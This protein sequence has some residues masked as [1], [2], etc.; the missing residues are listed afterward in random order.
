MREPTRPQRPCD[1]VSHALVRHGADPRGSSPS[2]RR[3]RRPVPRDPVAGRAPRSA[4]KTRE[5]A[6]ATASGRRRRVR[7]SLPVRAREAGVIAAERRTRNVIHRVGRVAF[8]DIAAS[9]ARL[10]A[11]ARE[12]FGSARFH[13]RDSLSA[14]RRL[15]FQ[16]LRD[17][18]RCGGP[19]AR[20]RTLHP[21]A[22]GNLGPPWAALPLVRH[23]GRASLWRGAA[24]R[25]LFGFGR[26]CQA[27]KQRRA[28][29]R[30]PRPI[31]G[32]ARD[33]MPANPAPPQGSPAA[34]A[35][36]PPPWRSPAAATERAHDAAQCAQG[37]VALSRRASPRRFHPPLASAASAPGDPDC[38]QGRGV[39]ECARR[40]RARSRLHPV[41]R[42]P[43][44]G[45]A[46][47]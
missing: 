46:S 33:K 6:G 10:P 12:L 15:F 1:S 41:L 24:R 4:K 34:A 20:H 8:A 26:G 16:R 29:H 14:R 44:G 11:V 35:E 3:S 13:R 25:S 31:M 7:A 32:A 9:A 47:F 19:L 42:C 22:N 18:Q 30:A 28:S 23:P 17:A 39:R 43:A 37:R 36:S 5:R 40:L 2:D 45:A 21:G 27:A 38:A